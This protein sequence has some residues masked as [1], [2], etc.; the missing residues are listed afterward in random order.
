MECCN[1][2][3][4]CRYGIDS[5]ADLLD[6]NIIS[7]FELQRDLGMT[8]EQ[9]ARVK[10]KKAADSSSL[11]QRAGSNIDGSH[12]DAG[13]SAEVA[14]MSELEL[15][16]GHV[17]A[18]RTALLA[19]TIAAHEPSAR[20]KV[21]DVLDRGLRVLRYLCVAPRILEC[22]GSHACVRA[23]VRACFINSLSYE[24]FVSFSTHCQSGCRWCN[25]FDAS[26]VKR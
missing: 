19:E 11:Q 15:S 21:V 5:L 10:D 7:T 25:S 6:D 9:A 14:S 18:G 3:A 1:F 24:T 12:G 16:F 26:G 22:L 17:S 4:S 8:P 23:C 13:S 20:S 2:Y